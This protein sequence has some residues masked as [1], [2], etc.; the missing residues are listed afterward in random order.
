MQQQTHLSILLAVYYD[1]YVVSLIFCAKSV[2]SS[3]VY[4]LSRKTREASSYVS[5]T[6]H[7][8]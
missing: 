3:D 2:L 5:D 8:S 4:F 1:A 6:A 7:H